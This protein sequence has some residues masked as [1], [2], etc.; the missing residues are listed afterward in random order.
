[1]NVIFQQTKTAVSVQG[2]PAP[3]CVSPPCRWLAFSIT[4]SAHIREVWKSF[5]FSDGFSTLPFKHHPNE[6]HGDNE[7]IAPYFK[8]SQSRIR[9]VAATNSTSRRSPRRSCRITATMGAGGEGSGPKSTTRFLASLVRMVRHEDPQII[10]WDHG[11]LVI[12]DPKRLVNEILEKYFRHSNYTSLQRQLNSFGF[13]KT[14]GKGRYERSI[15]TRQGLAGRPIEAILTVTRGIPS[16]SSVSSTESESAG[17]RSITSSTT[18]SAAASSR[19]G[20]TTAKL[21]RVSPTRPPK[22]Q[23]QANKILSGSDSSSDDSAYEDSSG[24]GGSDRR[25]GST[26]RFGSNVWPATVTST[27]RGGQPTGG[28][29]LPAAADGDG[30]KQRSASSSDSG[31]NSDCC[32]DDDNVRCQRRMTAFTT[33]ASAAAAAAVVAAAATTAASAAGA[34]DSGANSGLCGSESYCSVGSNSSS[35]CSGGGSRRVSP[36]K[37]A[38]LVNTTVQEQT[39]RAETA[40]HAPFSCSSGGGASCGHTGGGGMGGEKNGAAKDDGLFIRV[41]SFVAGGGGSGNGGDFARGGGAVRQGLHRCGSLIFGVSPRVS[42]G[43]KFGCG[44]HGG[45]GAG[46]GSFSPVGACF[47]VSEKALYGSASPIEPVDEAFFFASGTDPFGLARPPDAPLDVSVW[48]R[49]EV[50]NAVGVVRR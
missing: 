34:A 42:S 25:F 7:H 5:D 15:Y 18:S 19:K 4:M 14:E 10:S 39:C 30:G 20:R 38:V 37:D 23:R 44:R 40:W 47:S 49:L 17:R 26:G 33:A 31:C 29:R 28:R 8:S 12:N 36:N 27:R 41:G 2:R 48:A 3:V 13:H 45:G 46:S 43:C 6:S 32:S 50:R 16:V 9:S 24:G 21:H 11:R 22:R 35:F 1:M